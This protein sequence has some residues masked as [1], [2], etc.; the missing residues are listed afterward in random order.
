ML[1]EDESDDEKLIEA[2]ERYL[3]IRPRL[4]QIIHS[5]RYIIITNKK[6]TMVPFTEFEKYAMTHIQILPNMD[7]RLV[8]KHY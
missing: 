7:C 1:V 4:R 8:E 2:I 3:A 5:H 6:G